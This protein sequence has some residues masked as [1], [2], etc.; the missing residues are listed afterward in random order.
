MPTSN[1]NGRRRRILPAATG[2]I[3]WHDEQHNHLWINNRLYHVDRSPLGSDG[4]STYNL[5]YQEGPDEPVVTR[6]V[7]L[8]ERYGWSMATCNCD[9]SQKR[10]ERRH[11][12]K[13]ILGLRKALSVEEF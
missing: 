12:C 9:D 3:R 7:K 8:S 10:P 11:A 4:P 6:T 2:T 1:P 13:H 5:S